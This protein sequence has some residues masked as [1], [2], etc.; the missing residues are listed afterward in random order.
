MVTSTP[1][2]LVKADVVSQYIKRFPK[3]ATQTLARIAYKENPSLW[4]TLDACRHSF[5]YVRGADGSINRVKAA[6]RGLTRM[7]Q[8]PGDPFGRIPVPITD[9]WH[10]VPFRGPMNALVLCDLH[11]PYHNAKFIDTAV[12]QGKH[13]GCD[14]ILLNG[15]I[16]DCYAASHWQTDPRERNFKRERDKTREFLHYLRG[17]FPKARI[18]YKLGNHEERYESYMMCKAPE[19][20]GMPEF[21]FAKLLHFEELGIECV[22]DKMPIRLGKLNV[23]HGHEYRF[24]IQNPVNPARGLFMRGKVNALCG[25]FHRSSSHSEKSMEDKVVTCWSVGAGCGM[26]PDYMPLNSWNLGMARTEVDC[27]GA[28][29]VNNLRYVDGEMYE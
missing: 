27:A 9:G 5:R 6:V 13:Y 25:H 29:R 15:D 11:I 18:V 16:M 20:L 19:M 8:A 14:F 22:R 12:K 28:F 24:A 23:I 1:K 7:Q 4:V 17:Q 10:A 3:A 26:H 2:K 21:D